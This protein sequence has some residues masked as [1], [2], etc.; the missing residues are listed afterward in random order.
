MQS[1]SL[2]A[3]CLFCFI[4]CASHI[5]TRERSFSPI[6]ARKKRIYTKR[7]TRRTPASTKGKI[8]LEKAENFYFK[9]K[10]Q[11]TKGKRKTIK[12]MYDND[13]D[14]S[15][16]T[17][18]RQKNYL[19]ARNNTKREGDIVIINI[20]DKL[21]K[22]I[23]EEFE[24]IF[25]KSMNREING[26]GRGRGIRRGVA[27]IANQDKNILAIGKEEKIST[28]IADNISQDHFIIRGKKQIVHRGKNRMLVV[29]A[30]ISKNDIMNTDMID[31]DKILDI[32]VTALR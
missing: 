1:K 5:G 12:D 24:R 22:K 18:N 11:F 6:Y 15:L 10:E 32:K 30:L 3:F 7:N 23:A 13:S 2:L 17:E 26:R 21:R 8:N 4:S 20:G 29:D 16:W 27:S 14:G 9:S 31:S 28:I 25:S 19:F